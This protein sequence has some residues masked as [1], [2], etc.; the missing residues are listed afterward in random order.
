MTDPLIYSQLE[1]LRANML[2]AGNEAGVTIIEKAIEIIED[3]DIDYAYAVDEINR[4]NK[5]IELQDNRM[6]NWELVPKPPRPLEYG[7]QYD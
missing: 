4:L 2:I 5:V 6:K 3:L 7:D 1:D